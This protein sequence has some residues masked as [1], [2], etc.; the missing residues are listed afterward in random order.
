MKTV[1]FYVVG[2]LCLLATKLSAQETETFE[3]RAR[4]ISKTIE[5]ITKKQKDSLKV[6]VEAINAQLERNEISSADAAAKKQQLAEMRAKKIETGVAVEEQKLSDLVKDK[7]NGKIVSNPRRSRF[8][9]NFEKDNEDEADTTKVK[10]KT[11]EYKRTTSQFVLAF[12]INRLVADD[13]IDHANFKDRSEFYEWGVTWNTRLFKNNNLLHIKYGL[14]LQYN[15]LRADNNK[16]FAVDGNKTGLVDSGLD[17]DVSRFR[18]VNLVVPVH[19]E[20]DFTKKRMNGEK[21][22]FPT[23]QSFRVGFGGYTGF[24]VKEKQIVKYADASGND[25]KA[26]T[27]GDF[28]VND[29]VYGVSAYIG[30]GQTSLYAKYDLQT[31]FSN[32]DI[33]QNNLSLGVRFD[34]N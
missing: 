20:L 14:S 24:N 2:L 32:N 6:E 17:L 21:V 25:V 5:T 26:K 29:F 30:Y 4:T 11:F 8:S 28:N 13:K 16:I 23:H 34:F 10:I 22:Y 27:K 15:N 9:I 18:Y 31:I 3:Q 1:T 19:F 33:D 7:V 12:G